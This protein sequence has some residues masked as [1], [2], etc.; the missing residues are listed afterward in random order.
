MPARKKLELYAMPSITLSDTR[1]I[2]FPQVTLFFLSY[3]RVFRQ[4]A[5]EVGIQIKFQ[6]YHEQAFDN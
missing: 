3:M 2:R 5:A 4:V 6:V 1:N